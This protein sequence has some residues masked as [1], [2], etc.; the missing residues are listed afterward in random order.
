MAFL[1]SQFLAASLSWACL[2]PKSGR[3]DLRTKNCSAT[4]YLVL[5]GNSVH[6]R[7]HFSS[8]SATTHTT[9]NHQNFRSQLRAHAININMKVRYSLTLVGVTRTLRICSRT[10]LYSTERRILVRF[11]SCTP[12][13][14]PGNPLGNRPPNPTSTSISFALLPLDGI[15]LYVGCISGES[16]M[17][18]KFRI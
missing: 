12:P 7:S 15:L 1:A 18:C 9:S 11:C 2:L 13:L 8:R 6:P 4:A 3:R 16:A 14:N 5:Q 17:T 10:L